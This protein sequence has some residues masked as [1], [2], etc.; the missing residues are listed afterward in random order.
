MNHITRRGFTGLSLAAVSAMALPDQLHAASP[1]RPLGARHSGDPRNADYPYRA[2]GVARRKR[3]WQE[4]VTLNQ[5]DVG[6]CVGFAWTADLLA[7]PVT[8]AKPVTARQGNRLGRW[9]YNRANAIDGIDGNVDW[10]TV[11]A[12]AKVMQG[13]GLIE[14]YRWATNVDDIID[15]LLTRGPVVTLTPW[16]SQ[17]GNAPKGRV[18]VKGRRMGVDH[19]VLLTGYDPDR[20]GHES[21]RWRNSWGSS[22]GDGGSAW[23]KVEDFRNL[24]TGPNPA[25]PLGEACVPIG[26]NPAPTPRCRRRI[27]LLSPRGATQWV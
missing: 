4:G 20:D 19:C 27:P 6:A 26:R 16:L 17:M 11:L 24:W 10:T 15:A 23:I 14:S 18:V 22:Y 8:P 2:V 12:G 5:F 3:L 7:E 13:L 1:Q 21:L 25:L 9:I